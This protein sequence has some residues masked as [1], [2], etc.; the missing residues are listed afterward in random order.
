[1]A[2]AIRTIA[3]LNTQLTR[4]INSIDHLTDEVARIETELFNVRDHLQDMHLVLIAAQAAVQA[5][6][7]LPQP[8]QDVAVASDVQSPQTPPDLSHIPTIRF[9][10]G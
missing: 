9:P 3:E 7:A 5:G 2:A 4:L 1:M 6:T 8:Q 10:P